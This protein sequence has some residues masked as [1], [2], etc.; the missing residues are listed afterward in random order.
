M[1]QFE[2]RGQSE[3]KIE[4]YKAL[5]TDHQ[6]RIVVAFMRGFLKL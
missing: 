2:T 1:E 6:L 4:F 5:L 3:A